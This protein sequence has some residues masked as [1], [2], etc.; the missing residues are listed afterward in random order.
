MRSVSMN[1]LDQVPDRGV[2]I[3]P[4]VTDVIGLAFCGRGKVIKVKA[5]T[6]HAP[7]DQVMIGDE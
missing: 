3:L 6:S 5:E 7:S 2:Q 4:A 1:P